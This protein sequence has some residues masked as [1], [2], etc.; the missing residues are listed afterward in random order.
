MNWRQISFPACFCCYQTL[1]DWQRWDKIHF[2]RFRRFLV[3]RPFHFS[4]HA[5]STLLNWK[6]PRQISRSKRLWRVF[7]LCSER[8]LSGSSCKHRHARNE[9]YRCRNRYFF[10][11]RRNGWSLLQSPRQN[12]LETFWTWWKSLLQRNKNRSGRDCCKEPSLEGARYGSI[13][14]YETKRTFSHFPWRNIERF[15]VFRRSSER[16][17]VW[18]LLHI[19]GKNLRGWWWYTIFKSRF[20]SLSTIILFFFFHLFFKRFETNR[21]HHCIVAWGNSIQSLK[22]EVTRNHGQLVV[23]TLRALLTILLHQQ[24]ATKVNFSKKESCG[25]LMWRETFSHLVILLVAVELLLN[26]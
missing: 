17:Y 16:S 9:N 23:D 20:H 3:C 5:E 26:F 4:R 11:Q 24:P 13:L 14:P 10:S 19:F 1:I 6:I 25:K 7:R 2:M 12:P 18:G 15:Q 21:W 8:L 22:E